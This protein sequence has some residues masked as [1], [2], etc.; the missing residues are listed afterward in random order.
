MSDY[1]ISVIVPV[2][3]GSKTI[4]HCLESISKSSYAN[5]ECIVVDDRSSDNSVE[6]AESFGVRVIRLDAQ[7]GAAH[8]RNQGS[9]IAQG[10]ILLFIDSDVTIPPDLLDKVARTFKKNPEI[11]ALF[12]SYDDQPGSPNFISQYKN[13][14]HH[15]IHQTSRQEASTFWSGCGAVKREVFDAVSGFD[16][17]NY[18]SA[19]IEDIEMGSRLRK[20]GFQIL[21]EKDIQVKHLKYFSFF[22]LIKSD[23]FDRAIPWTTLMLKNK[24]LATDLNLKSEHKLSAAIILLILLTLVITTK[25]LWFALALPPLLT[26]FFHLNHDF[27]TFYINKKGYGFTLKVVPLHFLYYLYSTLG[28]FIGFC[29]Y[30]YAKIRD[31]TT[32]SI[33]IKSND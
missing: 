23:L 12:G 25:S 10:D 29:R 11:S 21:L 26:V 15:Y 4:S 7:K 16:H 31:K 27:Y 1:F 28:F 6:I 32:E 19:S 24:Q 2:Y 30:L 17:D 14:F 22:Y 18:S 33:P 8:A 13:L 3:N 5:F 9:K 20:M